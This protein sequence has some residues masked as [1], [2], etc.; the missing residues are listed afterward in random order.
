MQPDYQLLSNTNLHVGKYFLLETISV[1]YTLNLIYL[2]WNI[3]S[4]FSQNS[5]SYQ[6]MTEKNSR[7]FISC[8]CVLI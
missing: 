4:I 7:H 6:G 2:L 3:F 5:T 8:T 1:Q